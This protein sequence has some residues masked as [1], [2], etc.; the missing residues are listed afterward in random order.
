MSGLGRVVRAGVGRRRVQTVVMTLTTLLAV[1]ASVLAVGLLVASS[2]PFRHAFD[3]LQ[4]AHLAAEFDATKAT[5]QQLTTATVDGVT[6]VAGPF[7]TV[8]LRPH[9]LTGRRPGGPGQLGVPAGIDLPPTKLAGRADPGGDVDKLELTA[10]RWVSGPGEIVWSAGNVPFQLGD[11]LSFPEAP[12]NPTLTVVGLARSIGQSAQAWVSPDQLTALAGAGHAGDVPDAVPLRPGPRPTTTSRPTGRDRRRHAARRAH[13][14]GVLPHDPAGGGAHGGH[15]R[16]VRGGVRVLGLV[17]SILI[18][19]IV[20]GGAVSSATRRIGILKA[21]GYTP[22]QVARAFVGQALVPALVGAVL[23]VVLGNLAAVPVL[24]E[25]GDAFGTG[26][27]GLA[28]WVSV[29]RPIGAL[30]AV[31][32]AAMVPALRAGG[33]RT[34]DAIAVGRTPAVGRARHVPATAGPAA[35][36]AAGEPRPGQPVR[37]ADPIGDDRGRGGPRRARGHVRRRP[38]PVA[39]RHPGGPE[40]ARRRRCDRARVRR[41]ARPG[42]LGP[43]GGR[44]PR[45]GRRSRPRPEPS[46]T[47]APA[48]ARSAWPACPAPRRW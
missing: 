25:E 29:R 7:G 42:R 48:G 38:G 23:G 47:S 36:A 44:V 32:V 15:L 10:G 18:I 24:E 45:S 20:V 9:T 26:T 34:V 13:R 12:G 21:L 1:G 40:P 4:G 41:A 37:A 43:T 46:G 6:A 16:A 28:P 2:A 33:L 11:Q 27:P 35:A 31:A 8:S 22:A 14:R 5:T 17:M 3:R 39:G 19:S 30:I